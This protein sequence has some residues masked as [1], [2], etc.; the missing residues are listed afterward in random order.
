MRK[1]EECSRVFAKALELVDH[2][3]EYTFAIFEKPAD[4]PLLALAMALTGAKPREFCGRMIYLPSCNNQLKLRKDG[5]LMLNK[6]ELSTTFLHFGNRNLGGFLYTYLLATVE[7]HR[8]GGTGTIPKADYFK[9]CRKCLP[10]QLKRFIK[11]ILLRIFPKKVI[12][13]LKEKLK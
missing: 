8:N 6:N 7:Y 2:Y 13:N 10:H 4:E 5:K 12:L 9:I 11:N 3:D 1:T